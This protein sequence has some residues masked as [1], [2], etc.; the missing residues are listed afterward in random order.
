MLTY[1]IKITV[2]FFYPD[3]GRYYY[4]RNVGTHLPKLYGVTSNKAVFQ[5]ET[6]LKITD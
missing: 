6:M 5:M 4:L 2:F 1:I 3:N